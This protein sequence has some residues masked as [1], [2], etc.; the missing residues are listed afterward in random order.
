MPLIVCIDCD[1]DI[2]D[3]IENCPHCG[4]PVSLSKE[5]AKAAIPKGKGEIAAREN[6]EKKELLKT[7]KKK[8]LR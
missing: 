5:A 6:E 7:L 1:K 2:S 8:L 3:R 4:C